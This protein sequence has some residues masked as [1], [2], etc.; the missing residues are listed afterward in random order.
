MKVKSYAKINIGLNILYKRFD[1]Y[2]ELESVMSLVNI[3]DTITFEISSDKKI[4]FSCNINFL[5]NES[6]LIYKI[7]I[8][9]QN[10]FN[11]EKGVNI[12]LDKN[13]PVSGGMGGGSSNAATTI[14]TLNKIWNLNLNKQ[15]M[16]EIGCKFGA[17]IPFC[18]N[19]TPAVVKGIGEIIE[20][21]NFISDFD[22][23]VVKMPFGLSTKLVFDN[24]DVSYSKQFSI[25]NIKRS[26]IEGNRDALIKYLGN[27][28]EETSISIRPKIQ[29]VIDF[30][31]LNGCFTSIMSGSG[32]TVLGFT[33]KAFDSTNIEMKLTNDGYECFRTSIIHNL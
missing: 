6:N 24:F 10:K 22:I 13:L 18:I 9:L 1:G 27:N 30:L 28:L 26:L 14:I 5:N 11:I 15:D 19:Q 33:D 8:Y 29:K 31:N 17:D 4:N 12:H 7:A 2:H 21:F 23:I 16:L 20:P 25:N 32:P 3:Y